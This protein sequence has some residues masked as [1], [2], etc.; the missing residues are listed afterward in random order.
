MR[1]RNVWV[2]RLLELLFFPRRKAPFEDL[3]PSWWRGRCELVVGNFQDVILRTYNFAELVTQSAATVHC[4][5][6]AWRGVSRLPP[7]DQQVGECA[8]EPEPAR[9][10]F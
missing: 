10:P 8:V 7:A 3:D 9:D 4:G 2:I 5:A 1:K 6:G